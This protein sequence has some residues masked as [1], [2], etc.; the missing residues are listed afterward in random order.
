MAGWGWGT[1]QDLV[2]LAGEAAGFGARE[3]IGGGESAGTRDPPLAVAW[4]RHELQRV[5]SSSAGGW[6]RDG[7]VLWRGDAGVVCRR[8]RGAK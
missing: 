8:A 6:E 5:D 3:G 4:R 7:V 2:V 1:A